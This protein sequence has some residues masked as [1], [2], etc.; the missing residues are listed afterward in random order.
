[1][2]EAAAFI[3]GIL[4]HPVSSLHIAFSKQSTQTTQSAQIARCDPSPTVKLWTFSGRAMQDQAA[5]GKISWWKEWQWSSQISAGVDCNDWCVSYCRRT[6]SKDHCW[7][8][9]LSSFSLW[10]Q[11]EESR[12][13]LE[14]LEFFGFS[15]QLFSVSWWLHFSRSSLEAAKTQSAEEMWSDA[16]WHQFSISFHQTFIK[17]FIY[18]FPHTCHH[19]TSWSASG[20]AR[21]C[22][23]GNPLPAHA[24]KEFLW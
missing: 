8:L 14:S 20:I 12:A 6:P 9:C 16:H 24:E 15:I 13:S 7:R 5:A 23:E 21:P 17:L 2:F 10:P 3:F 19:G 22:Q 4:Q 1:M 11:T 18:F